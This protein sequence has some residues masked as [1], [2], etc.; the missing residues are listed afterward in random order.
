MSNKL[1][2]YNIFYIYFVILHPIHGYIFNL[3]EI[4]KIIQIKNK[5]D[6]L[7]KEL[8]DTEIKVTTK[9]EIKDKIGLDAT[10]KEKKV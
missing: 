6:A 10:Q 5:Y 3:K 1:N 9:K 4:N 2:M 7:E 8:Q